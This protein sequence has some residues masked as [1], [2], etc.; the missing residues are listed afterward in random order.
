MVNLTNSDNGK[1]FKIIDNIANHNLAMGTIVTVSN[2]NVGNKSCTVNAPNIHAF[3]TV[4]FEDLDV[5]IANRKDIVTEINKAK[6]AIA[7]LE[8]KLEYL[9]TTGQENYDDNEFKVYKVLAEVESGKNNLEKAKAIAK[10]I[11]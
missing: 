3:R 8:I 7:N 4:Y 5:A 2:I 9:D 10:L 1:T 6:E 11:A